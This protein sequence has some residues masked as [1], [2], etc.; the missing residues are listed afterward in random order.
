MFLSHHHLAACL[1]AAA[2]ACGAL[3]CCWGGHSCCKPGC[4]GCLCRH[5][6]T[7]SSMRGS[8]DTDWHA[9]RALYV[10]F[11]SLWLSDLQHT[12]CCCCPCSLFAGSRCP[13]AYA[14]TPND[15]YD[16]CRSTDQGLHGFMQLHYCFCNIQKK[17]FSTHTG[18]SRIEAKTV[19]AEYNKRFGGSL[20][21]P[22]A[23][24][25]LWSDQ[26]GI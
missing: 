3:C 1:T 10:V 14:A 21:L 25:V 2:A 18:R 20:G 9:G 6:H 4:A 7:K 16:Q 22:M 24:H 26:P 17:G 5:Q 15:S 12:S 19:G 23:C 11:C 8:D 13:K